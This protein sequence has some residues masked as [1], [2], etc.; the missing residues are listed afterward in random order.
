MQLFIL[1]QPDDAIPLDYKLVNLRL[2][3]AVSDIPSGVYYTIPRAAP[4]DGIVNSF[5]YIRYRF[6]AYRLT[7]TYIYLHNDE[8]GNV[9][10]G[11]GTPGITPGQTGEH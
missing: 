10:E 6:R 2:P 8:S 9:G 7:Y 1:G 11:V 4:S 5:G 3:S